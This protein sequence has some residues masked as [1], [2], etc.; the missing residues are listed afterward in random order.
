MS[1]GLRAGIQMKIALIDTRTAMLG[2]IIGTLHSIH[3]TTDAAFAANEVFQRENGGGKHIIT[4][5]VTL[6][7][8]IQPGELVQPGDLA[9]SL[10]PDK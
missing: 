5:I 1:L 2:K 7:R 4:K 3:A 8:P 9:G 6:K 10:S